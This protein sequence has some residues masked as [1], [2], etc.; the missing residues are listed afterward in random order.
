M[1]CLLISGGVGD[2]GG[3]KERKL[4]FTECVECVT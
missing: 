2:K 4:K 1:E 3:G